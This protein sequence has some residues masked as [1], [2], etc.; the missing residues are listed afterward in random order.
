MTAA[1]ATAGPQRFDTVRTVLGDIPMERLGRCDYHEHLFRFPRCWSV[2]NS[3]TNRPAPRRL[4]PCAGLVSTR[5][6]TPHLPVSGVIPARS[7]ASV[8]PPALPLCTSVELTIKVTTRQHIGY[9]RPT[10]TTWSIAFSPTSET[11]CQ[12]KTAAIGATWPLDQPASP[13]ARAC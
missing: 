4:N 9:S 2:T 11:A 1:S 12:P 3:T 8:A 10:K 7:P 13:C 5:S 6:S